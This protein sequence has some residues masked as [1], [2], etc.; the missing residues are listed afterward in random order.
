VCRAYFNVLEELRGGNEERKR[1][2]GEELRN[3]KGKRKIRE[4]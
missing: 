2:W 1:A 4:N 3:K